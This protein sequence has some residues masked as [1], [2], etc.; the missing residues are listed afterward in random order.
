MKL[1]TR[2]DKVESSLTPKQAVVLWLQEI[3]QYQ[4][5]CEYVQFLRTQPESAATHQQRA[6]GAHFVRQRL[7]R[8]GIERLGGDVDEIGL[9]A[10]AV[11]PV[12]IRARRE[13]ETLQL[14]DCRRQHLGVVLA[15][16]DPLTESVLL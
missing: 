1:D 2:L 15:V 7:Q 5:V 13:A 9:R 6:L 4:N 10:V 14:G 3:R 11:L 8:L 12:G 16:D